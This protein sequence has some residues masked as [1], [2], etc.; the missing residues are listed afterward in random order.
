MDGSLYRIG[1]AVH[2]GVTLTGDAQHIQIA[3]SGNIVKLTGKVHSWHERESARFR[4]RRPRGRTDRSSPGAPRPCLHP[5]GQGRGAVFRAH[6][7]CDLGGRL[8][9]ASATTARCRDPLR[10][11]RLAGPIA[12]ATVR[13]GGCVVCGIHMSDIPSF[14]DRLLWAE[15]ELR[16]VANLTRAD[17]TASLDTAACVPL[18][19]T[20]RPI[21]WKRRTKRSTTRRT[22]VGRS[23]CARSHRDR[24]VP[25]RLPRRCLPS[26]RFVLSVHDLAGTGKRV[27]VRLCAYRIDLGPELAQPA[28]SGR[29]ESIRR[30]RTK[31]R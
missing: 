23:G 17:A 12:L 25:W 8:R 15:R 21:R 4:R 3:I 1:I 26:R 5:P 20:S 22:G 10:A 2:D 9:R 14:R 19:T 13:K 24:D 27:A 28:C 18:R 11:R 6:S 31:R 29:R 30:F 16:S 7:R